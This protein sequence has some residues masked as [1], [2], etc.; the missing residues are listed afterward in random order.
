MSV[1][2][3]HAGM[4]LGCFC[5]G[6]G[7]RREQMAPHSLE[8]PEMTSRM[9][10]YPSAIGSD[11]VIHKP[12]AHLFTADLQSVLSS[13]QNPETFPTQIITMMTATTNTHALKSEPLNTLAK[14]KTSFLEPIGAGGQAVWPVLR[15][16]CSVVF[17]PVFANVLLK[18]STWREK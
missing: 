3:R 6:A 8:M 13:P 12:N 11:A 14:H 1:G 7:L 9:I 2:Q 10:I 17:P 4:C 18:L 16:L 15:L 5:R